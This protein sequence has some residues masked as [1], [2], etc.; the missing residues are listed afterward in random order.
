MGQGRFLDSF[1]TKYLRATSTVGRCVWN[2][3]GALLPI[4][5]GRPSS[6]DFGLPKLPE[7]AN[8]RFAKPDSGS[9]RDPAV[10]RRSAHKPSV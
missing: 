3:L 6:T 7:G 8:L 4:A 10:R 2:V 9:G 5:V 1:L